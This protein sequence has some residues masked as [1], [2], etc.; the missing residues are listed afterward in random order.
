MS[1]VF[2]MKVGQ[3]GR[4]SPRTRAV[5]DFAID[6]EDHRNGTYI[7]T[8]VGVRLGVNAQFITA[9]DEAVYT[10]VFGDRPGDLIIGG[11]AFLEACN[12]DAPR[13]PESDRC[14][15]ITRATKPRHVTRSYLLS[16]DPRRFRR[17]CS[18]ANWTYCVPSRVRH[19]ISS[20]SSSCRPARGG[21][22]THWWRKII[23]PSIMPSPLPGQL[24]RYS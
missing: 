17:V 9:F 10:Y 4:I 22:R 13:A 15:T 8:S 16:S 19:S 20:C 3:V 11:L 5:V 2:S 1:A 12:P 24:R 21:I 23:S 6:F 14:S 18:S 7:V